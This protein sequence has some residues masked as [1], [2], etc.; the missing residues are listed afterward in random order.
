M[1][2]DWR[3]HDTEEARRAFADAQYRLDNFS[4]IEDGYT[5]ELRAT[6]HRIAD[7][8]DRLV[9]NPAHTEFER[10]C[11]RAEFDLNFPE[12]ADGTVIEWESGDRWYAARRQDLPEI[13]GG[14]WWLYGDNKP[15]TWWQLVVEFELRMDDL[16]YLVPQEATA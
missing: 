16:T 3:I 15:R 5:P 13:D 6:D 11:E 8:Y 10:D 2:T 7:R 1:T 9:L 14:A 12:P 4:F